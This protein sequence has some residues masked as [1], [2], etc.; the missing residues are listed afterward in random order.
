LRITLGMTML[1]LGMALPWPDRHAGKY[2]TP[3]A[4]FDVLGLCGPLCP[5]MPFL[6][7]WGGAKL[8]V[9]CRHQVSVRNFFIVAA[10]YLLVLAGYTLIAR[11]PQ[12]GGIT[13]PYLDY[14]SRQAEASGYGGSSLFSACLNQAYLQRQA[15]AGGMLG[16]LIAFPLSHMV[17]RIGASLLVGALLITLVGIFLRFQPGK[18]FQAASGLEERMREK[19]QQ[20]QENQ[21]A[22]AQENA[23]AESAPIYTNTAPADTATPPDRYRS[24]PIYNAQPA[25]TSAPARDEQG[26]YAVQPDLYEERFP[27]DEKR[28]PMEKPDWREAAIP[29]DVE[30]E[31]APE[32][33]EK[34]GV[35][36]GLLNLLK[37]PA[38]ILRQE[39]PVGTAQP[40]EQEQPAGRRRR[41][42]RSAAPAPVPPRPAPSGQA[43]DDEDDLPWE[44]PEGA[45]V[46]PSGPP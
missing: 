2:R 40:A 16:M 29:V 28:P 17:T 18:L 19:R 21:P 7:S 43:L 23:P 32:K 1:T 38:P 34:P 42:D 13:L 35:F 33:Q 4:L 6:L 31:P 5:G 41:S 44:V 8:L 36:S 27:S 11:V 10:L 15:S 3:G 14:V 22:P 30:K 9:S 45:V 20:R 26:F 12:G 37:E 25:Y 24:A 39:T 46:K